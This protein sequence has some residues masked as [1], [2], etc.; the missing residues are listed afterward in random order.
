MFI[1]RNTYSNIDIKKNHL[2]MQLN[3]KYSVG[4]FIAAIMLFSSLNFL[5]AA[6]TK[7]YQPKYSNPFTEPWRWQTFPELVGKG[8]RC[9]LEDPKGSLWFGVNGGVLRYDGLNW[10]YYALAQDSSNVS[11]VSLLF[12]SDGSLYVGTAK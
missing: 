11:V 4:F 1:K 12:A 9:M 8:C 3:P 7:S 2:Y 5:F 10:K 6:E